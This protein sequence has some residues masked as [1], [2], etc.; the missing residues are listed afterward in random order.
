M[1]ARSVWIALQERAMFSGDGRSGLHLTAR[2]RFA[3]TLGG[4]LA[5]T[6]RLRGM[7]HGEG[8]LESGDGSS[9]LTGHR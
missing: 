1:D 9:S 3:H 8:L 6:I 7:H 5:E 4:D 2:D